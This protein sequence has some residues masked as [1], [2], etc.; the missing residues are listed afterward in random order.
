MDDLTLSRLADRIGM[1]HERTTRAAAQQINYW[2]TI[3]NWCI[4]WYI[5]EYEQ[6][7]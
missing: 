7:G 4:G 2:L 5:V 3:R 1:L 6:A